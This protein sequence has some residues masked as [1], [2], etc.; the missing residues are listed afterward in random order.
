MR[1]RASD[2]ERA[3]PYVLHPGMQRAGAASA[4]VCTVLR[5]ELV[6]SGQQLPEVAG[7][8][9]QIVALCA[10]ASACACPVPVCPGQ[11]VALCA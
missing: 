5:G 8:H 6:R 1:Q 3:P 2:L 4:F 9:G 7:I 10:Q 11:I